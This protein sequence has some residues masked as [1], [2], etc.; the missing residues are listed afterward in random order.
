MRAFIGVDRF[1][2]NHMPHDVIFLGNT[3][4]AMHVA[5]CP[6][7]GQRL[8]TII[9]FDQRNIFRCAIILVKQAANP[10]RGLQS[11]GD[12]GLHIGKL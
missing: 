6:R 3:I 10:K 12:V 5:R 8:A 2:I 7:N 11:K 9:A 4:A 1:Q